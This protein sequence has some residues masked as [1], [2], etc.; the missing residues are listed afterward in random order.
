M[1]KRILVLLTAIAFSCGAY[2]QGESGRASLAITAKNGIVRGCGG[3]NMKFVSYC[4][5]NNQGHFM[6]ADATGLYDSY[7]V[8]QDWQILDFRVV[9]DRVVF[10]GT[11]KKQTTAIV[12]SLSGFEV[13]TV[14]YTV[15]LLGFFSLNNLT[16][17]NPLVCK[18]IEEDSVTRFTKVASYSGSQ[19]LYAIGEQ[20]YK[21]PRI[22]ND[23]VVGYY[24]GHTPCMYLVDDWTQL[25]I[26]STSY[27]FNISGAD[28]TDLSV[29][30]TTVVAVGDRVDSVTTGLYLI[31]YTGNTLTGD[32][33]FYQMYDEPLSDYHSIGI[34]GK[35]VAVA[36]LA[37]QSNTFRTSIR[38]VEL[39]SMQMVNS[40]QIALVT[41]AEPTELASIPHDGTIVLQQDMYLPSNPSN[42]AVLN[43]RID[44]TLTSTYNTFGV[45]NS[46]YY[47]NSVTNMASKYAVAFDGI[48]WLMKDMTLSPNP[49]C[50]DIESIRVD[51]LDC[52]ESEKV[53]WMT[54]AIPQPYPLQTDNGLEVLPNNY[55]CIP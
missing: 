5:Y 32:E 41:K 16:S 24:T 2:A 15:G 50:Y 3:T 26:F 6:L 49:V 48:H 38:F 20:E 23:V 18:A 40:Q 52:V 47:Y 19:Y 34:V 39:D 36:C 31:R 11:V 33:Y 9:G 1:T 51:P 43:I 30:G 27:K 29:T 42:N 22:V 7:G 4:E 10:C 54:P 21:V 37:G 28:L 44:P 55:D 8:D 35:S 14:Y 25:P 53:Q 45:Y 13:I 17:G 12:P 46:G